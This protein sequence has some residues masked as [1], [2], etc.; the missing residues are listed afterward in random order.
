MNRIIERR[1]HLQPNL[2]LGAREGEKVS[3]TSTAISTCVAGLNSLAPANAIKNL[4]QEMA[5]NASCNDTGASLC[6]PS[7]DTFDDGPPSRQ[8]A[9]KS[10][11][12]NTC[13]HVEEGA[14]IKKKALRFETTVRVRDVSRKTDEQIEKVWY[15]HEEQD[16]F[17]LQA[18]KVVKL[19]RRSKMSEED[20]ED[21]HQESTQGLGHFINKALFKKLDREKRD[22]IDAVLLLQ[23]EMNAGGGPIDHELLAGAC[24]T[25][26]S[27][28]RERAHLVGL[29][30]SQIFAYVLGQSEQQQ[31]QS[32]HQ[33][34]GR[35]YMP[36]R[37]L[38]NNQAVGR[39]KSGV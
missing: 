34:G 14:K 5:V 8:R 9:T 2:L 21:E 1:N 12:L 22:V 24:S 23:E 6:A 25:L 20:F 19:F 26:S 11:N 30:I 31:Q 35:D 4:Q 32:S 7:P 15:S 13:F 29:G 28:A 3:S 18:Q 33:R 27:P 39:K 38:A 37:C 36:E 10:D 17:V 16:Q